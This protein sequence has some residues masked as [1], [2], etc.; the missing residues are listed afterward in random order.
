M[1]NRAHA[2]T[3]DEVTITM[4]NQ[5]AVRVAL[6]GSAMLVLPP[7]GDAATPASKTSPAIAGH[8]WQAGDAGCFT[9]A[10]SAARNACTTTKKFLI[11]VHI[12]Y[13]GSGIST[14]SLSAA[15]ENDTTKT[16]RP[17][18]RGVF[19]DLGNGLFAQTQVVTIARGPSY[20]SVGVLP[21][22]GNVFTG[23]GLGVAHLDCDLAASS[24]SGLGLTAM[25]W[26]TQ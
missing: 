8:A 11:P 26:V 6:I 14:L 2:L 5:R 9:S 25:Q 16:V 10:W 13:G 24:A 20:T 3:L 1:G 17:A 4:I 22:G 19:N 15:A 23:Q 21:A 7:L 18:C 12:R